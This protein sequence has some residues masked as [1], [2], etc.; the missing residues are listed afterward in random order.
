MMSFGLIAALSLATL[1]W[2]VPVVLKVAIGL[3]AVIFVHELGHFLVAK[4]CGVKCEK[5][6]I[7]FDIGGYKIARRWGETLYGIGI[8]PLGGY[9]KMLGQDD[10]P[11]HIAEQM[12]KSQ[13]NAQN[14]DAVPIQGPNGE[15]YYIDH[16]S[17]LAKSVPQRMA[18]ISAGVIMNVIFAFIFAV[19]AYGMGV[20]Y[21]PAVVSEVVPGSAAYRAN[22]QPGDEIVKIGKLENPSF[23]QLRSSVTLGDLEKGI[24]CKVRRAADDKVVDIVLKPEQTT[25]HLA[26]IGL[27]APFS[28]TLADDPLELKNTPVAQ[29][30]LIKPSVGQISS[31]AAKIM[32]GDE[33]VRAGD[34]AV[35]DYPQLAALLA[36]QPDKAVQII[37]RRAPKRDDK[38]AATKD[39]AVA[40]K[41]GES[42]ELTFEVPSQQLRRFNFSMKMGPITSVRLDSPAA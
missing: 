40:E 15:T 11:A 14:A 6:M 25:G 26:T 24:D 21:E 2:L 3:G 33:L 29:A 4:A 12:Q 9:V 37:V 39:E 34:V 18:I 20:P 31:D 32:E 41:G 7:G 5:F 35:K 28:L 22:I 19:I 8:L 16:R 17:Y 36:R 30:K 38:T 1:M 23:L 13:L 10:D 42:Q 27:V